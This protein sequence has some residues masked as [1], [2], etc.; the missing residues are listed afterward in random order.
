M[1]WD[2]VGLGLV[3]QRPCGFTSIASDGIIGMNC[4]ISQY[5]YLFAAGCGFDV[6]SKS[7]EGKSREPVIGL[8]TQRLAFSLEAGTS[9][10]ATLCHRFRLRSP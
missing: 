3:L 2:V 5:V 1:S 4:A 6:V 9:L 8:E 10:T 7:Y